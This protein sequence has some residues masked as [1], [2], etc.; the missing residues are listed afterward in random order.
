MELNNCTLT[1]RIGKDAELKY[2]PGGTA[3]A[4]FSIAQNSKRGDQEITQWHDCIVFGK[5]AE[6]FGP[7]LTKGMAVLV[8]GSIEKQ[9]WQDKD[10]KTQYRTKI[11]CNYIRTLSAGARSNEDVRL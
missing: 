1:G 6:M 9:S 5:T 11:I 8:D 2:T 10:G 3:I 4:E 7:G